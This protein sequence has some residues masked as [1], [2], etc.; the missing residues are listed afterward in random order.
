MAIQRTG[1]GT[2]CSERAAARAEVNHCA[3]AMPLVGRISGGGMRHRA[4]FIGRPP[5]APRGLPPPWGGQLL[6][7]LAVAQE[8]QVRPELDAEGS[9]QRPPRAVLDL[10]VPDPR[11]LPQQP[12]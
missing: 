6:E 1:T 12:N 2:A 9:P 3:S 10:D 5:P 4:G 8:D 11:I 7:D